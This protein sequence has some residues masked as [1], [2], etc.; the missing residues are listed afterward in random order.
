MAIANIL[1]AVILGVILTLTAPSG[2]GWAQEPVTLQSGEITL[3]GTLVLAD[4]QTLSDGVILLTHGTLAHN[5]ME[6]I[7]GLQ[8]VLE[9]RGI[10]TLAITL[11]LGISD[12]TGFYDCTIPSRHMHQDGVTEIGQWVAWLKDQGAQG[13]TIMGHSRGGN[14]TAWFAAENASAGFSRVILLAPMLGDPVQQAAGYE[15][16]YGQPLEP[17]LSKAQDMVA[18]GKGD[19]LMAVPG[20]LYCKDTKASAAAFV[21][22]Y[23][24]EPR[25]DTATLLPAIAQPVLVIGGTADQVV[26]G[27]QAAVAPLSDDKNLTLVMI[28]DADHSFLDFSAEDVADAI[29]DFLKG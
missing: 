5:G 6:T 27:L 21:S 26:T 19:D 7:Q 3:N 12:R 23:A 24:P 20:L 14:Q 17:L 29:E 1:K 2:K 28:E 9:E 4:G 15:A 16:R 10:S 18:A 13:I 25:R 8:S 11:G 22:Y